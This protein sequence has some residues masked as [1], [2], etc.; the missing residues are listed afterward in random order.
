MHLGLK[1]TQQFFRKPVRRM[2]RI[3]ANIS[4]LYCELRMLDRFEAAAASGFDGV[5]MQFPYAEPGEALAH[6][7]VA[8]KMPV[9]LINA[10]VSREHPTGLA[11][12]PEMRAAFRSQL[13]QIRDYAE[14]LGV[15]FVHVLAGRVEFPDERELCCAIY[16][17][18]LLL[19]ADVLAP[20]GV[21]V[22][23]EA[24][25][26]HDYPNYL[27]DSL[28]RADSILARCRQRIGLQFDLYH[29][30][31][32]SQDPA[33]QLAARLPRVR[34]VQFADVPGRHEPGTG[35]LN[36]ESSLSVLDA[37]GYRGWLSAEYSPV[38]ATATGLGW[39]ESWRRSASR[40]G[41]AI[42][43]P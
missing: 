17:E 20:L 43:S 34:H 28:D 1:K 39:L 14:A 9:V 35:A 10:P 38:A 26:P 21:T 41:P 36:F 19:A 6:A 42:G 29:V 25:N 2:T 23:I 31:R 33:A 4:M 11:G 5:E 16:A 3:A 24:L 27:V 40:S 12:R 30:A 13:T 15:D 8:A 32:M 7:A 37:C 18:N 22:L